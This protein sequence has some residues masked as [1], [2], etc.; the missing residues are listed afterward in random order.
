MMSLQV[1]L[2]QYRNC[3]MV[4]CKGHSAMR[5]TLDAIVAKFKYPVPVRPREPTY[6]LELTGPG[7]FTD[8][9][10]T[11][12]SSGPLDPPK[13]GRLRMPNRHRRLARANAAPPPP[14]PPLPLR[15]GGATGAPIRPGAGGEAPLL[16]ISRLAGHRYFRHVGQVR[17]PL[18]RLNTPC[19]ACMHLLTR[20]MRAY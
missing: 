14:P 18:C 3:V 7:V 9:I 6:T 16:H 2:P 10:K 19:D 1:R 13:T 8:A 5:A 20:G 4:S 11:L 12:Q 15:L 17:V